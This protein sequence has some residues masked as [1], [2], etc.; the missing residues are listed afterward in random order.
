MH[1]IQIEVSDQ[2]AAQ[3]APYREQLPNL[4]EAGLRAWQRKRRRPAETEAER[5]RRVLAASGL[6]TLP[7]PDPN[8]EATAR[9]RPVPITG[10]PVSEIA[11]EQRGER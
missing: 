7:K 4:L 6:V 3:L 10:K 9:R 5:I 2:L 11:I 8:P 1:T